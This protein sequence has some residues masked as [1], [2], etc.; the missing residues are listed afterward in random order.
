MIR[1]Y[2]MR[3]SIDTSNND[4]MYCVLP[5]VQWI[6]LQTCALLGIFIYGYSHVPNHVHMV[7]VKTR[8]KKIIVLPATCSSQGI[9]SRFKK[10]T[11]KS[12]IKR[13]SAGLGV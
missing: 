13:H 5:V 3:Q 12:V 11:M 6:Y 10:N 4:N 2:E 1:I 9:L 8:C 7:L